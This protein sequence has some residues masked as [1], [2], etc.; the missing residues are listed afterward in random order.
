MFAKL[1]GLLCSSAFFWSVYEER[2]KIKCAECRKWFPYDLEVVS[3]PWSTLFFFYR[4]MTLVPTELILW[5]LVALHVHS[6]SW[7]IKSTLDFEMN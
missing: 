6:R 1:V 2:F 4:K 7:K 5:E 3:E